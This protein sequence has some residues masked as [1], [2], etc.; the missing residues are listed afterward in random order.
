MNSGSTILVVTGFFNVVIVQV[1]S[2]W[3]RFRRN[4]AD[5]TDDDYTDIHNKKRE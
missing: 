2:I 1:Y 3:I 5:I 4:R